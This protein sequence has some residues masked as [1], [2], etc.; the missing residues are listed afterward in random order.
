MA[1]FLV[2]AEYSATAIKG[3]VTAPSDREAAARALFSALGIKMQACYFSMAHAGVVCILE[4]TAEQM[5]A[6]RLITGA[7]GAFTT[8]ETTEL[9][10]ADSM[11][12]AMRQ[13]AEVAGKY[14]APG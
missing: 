9:I 2:Q 13:A 5:T 8:L 1:T 7:S 11:N 4:G 14:Q 10:S 3:M 6:A 12:R